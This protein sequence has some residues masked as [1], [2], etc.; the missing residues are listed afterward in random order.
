MREII[1]AA[2]QRQRTTMLV[3]LLVG[4]AA[5]LLSRWADSRGTLPSLLAM[6]PPLAVIALV[7]RELR[8]HPVTGDLRVDEPGAVFFAPPRH[9]LGFPPV[10]AAWMVVVAVDGIGPLPLTV[11]LAAT[12]V[13][14]VVTHWIRIPLVALDPAGVRV[15][16][17]GA[18]VVPWDAL[19]PAAVAVGRGGRVR[20][21]V[22][23]PE[24]VEPRRSGRS[25]IDLPVR[26]LAVAPALLVAAIRHYVIHPEHRPAIGT[27]AEHARLR[28]ELSG[29]GAT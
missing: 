15:G 25:E 13:A 9:R 1:D 12:L 2:L 10:I 19:D 22:A 27:T 18:L 7:F 17:S 26:D 16:S 3:A 21:V 24:R 8:S 23:R 11:L 4:L 28:Q 5:G 29:G 6:I 20:L 14:L